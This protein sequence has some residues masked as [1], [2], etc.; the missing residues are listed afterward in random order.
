MTRQEYSSLKET[1]EREGKDLALRIA[2]VIGGRLWINRSTI[3]AAAY[4]LF[5]AGI[6]KVDE[7]DIES[8]CKSIDRDED[9]KAFLESTIGD[10]WP[11]VIG[12]R[13]RYS[14]DVLKSVII[15]GDFVDEH[16]DDFS[17]TPESVAKLACALFGFED[18]ATV[19]DF[20]VG[21]GNF[22]AEAHLLNPTLHFYGVDL[23]ASIKEITSIKCEI[24]GCTAQIEH[25]NIFDL[26][27]ETHQFKYVFSNYPFGLRPRD[28]GAE[29][30]K[31]IKRTVQK[32]PAF[33]R[34]ISSDWMFNAA[35]VDCIE[36]N[37]KGIVIMS[38]GSSWNNLEKNIRQYF[39]ENGFVEAVITLPERLFERAGLS[40]TMIVFS[41]NNKEVM[42]VDATNM[43]DKGRRYT[44]FSDE[45][46]SDIVYA[47]NNETDHS[48]RID[49]KEL[50]ENDYVISATRY[51]T[52]N[53]V[54]E[55]GVPFEQI[56]K[57][58]KRGSTLSAHEV[59]ALFTTEPTDYQYVKIGNIQFGMIDSDLS[60]LKEIPD[61][62]LRYCIKN[63][64]LIIAKNGMT[65]KI[66][67]AEV[68]PG[69]TILA[70]GNLYVIEI[71]E[72]KA[73]PY[74]VKAYLESEQGSAILKAI[75]VGDVTRN[76]SIDS[77][78]RISIPNMP[79]NE[80]HD[81]STKYQAKM[82][83]VSLLKRKF[84]KTVEELN[85]FFDNRG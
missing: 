79:L 24:L 31:L 3:T 19:A 28:W 26:D 76:I 33:S 47:T 8:F 75:S 23:N 11:M 54:I 22:L 53:I 38:N 83:E 78:R 45:Q 73:D 60:Y 5:M 84:E 82:D 50:A 59:D 69:K 30:N 81:F 62:Q 37:G 67:V 56:I 34:S 80:Q 6:E 10:T 4:V 51:L 42:L 17:K 12:Q 21:T 46:I 14:S 9:R 15:F 58:I 77:I 52:E 70:S 64:S 44:T 2:D 48:K 16:L 66:A 57:S 29:W 71:D 32:T 68:E 13:Y 41:R 35:I 61:N 7:T 49:I 63:R 74:F 18:G 1:Y 27:T 65:F 20:G 25:D 85:H 43:C 40:T 55:D 72:S 39:I 36:P